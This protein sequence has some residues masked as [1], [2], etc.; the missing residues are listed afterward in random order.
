MRD[1]AAYMRAYPRVPLTDK[2][3][4]RYNAQKRRRYAT[5]P[6]F[7]ARQQAACL[8]RIRAVRAA[9]RAARLEAMEGK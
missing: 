8:A 4:A 2:Q 5:D 3:R 9:A 7:R 1:M 6:V